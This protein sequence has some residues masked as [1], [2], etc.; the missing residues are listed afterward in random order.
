[1]TAASGAGL[2]RVR[3]HSVLVVEDNDT[4][5]G[6][7]KDIL[8][9]ERLTVYTA[10]DGKEGVEQVLAHKPDI[11]IMDIC[12]PKLNGVTLC[13]AIRSCATTRNIPIIVVSSQHNREQLE[14]CICAGADDFIGKPFDVTDLLI[15]VRAMIRCLQ[16][17]DIPSR[18]QDYIIAVRELRAVTPPLRSSTAQV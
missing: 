9:S 17:A 4:M 18:L 3:S 12:M 14:Q 7:I 2:A 15:R 13:K 1:M 8:V 16:V 5:R 11:I 6:F 10:A